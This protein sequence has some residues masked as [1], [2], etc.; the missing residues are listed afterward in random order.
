MKVTCLV[1]P[2]FLRRNCVQSH[3]QISSLDR[4]VCRQSPEVMS[5]PVCGKIQQISCFLLSRFAIGYDRSQ[6]FLYW[7]DTAD[8]RI[9]RQKQNDS[10]ITRNQD[11]IELVYE[12]T[13]SQVPGMAVD[14]YSRSVY[15]TDA[16]A[17]RIFMTRWNQGRH[18]LSRVVV[19]TGLDHPSG[20]VVHPARG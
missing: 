10:L 7:S 1:V 2:V 17:K 12:G 11:T 20:V 14:W 3:V 4:R 16:E 6:Q 15:W 8:R 19:D 18:D 13:S 9:Y 5:V